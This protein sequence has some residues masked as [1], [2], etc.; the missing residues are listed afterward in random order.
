MVLI[1]GFAGHNPVNT[2]FRPHFNYNYFALS[3]L[4]P[5]QL[6]V[7]CAKLIHTY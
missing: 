1:P 4:F 3:G 2:L 5:A 7:R 6:L